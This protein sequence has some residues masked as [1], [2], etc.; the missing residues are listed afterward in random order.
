MKRPSFLENLFSGYFALVMAT[1]IVSIATH[2]LKMELLAYSLFKI[3]Q[4]CYLVLVVLTLL[5]LIF[6]P[7][8]I[9]LDLT[10]HNRGPGFFTFVAGSC[11]LGIQFLFFTS[12]RGIPLGLWLGGFLAWFIVMYVFFTAATVRSPK[13]TLE[14]G[15]NGAWLLAVVATQSLSILGTLL[16]KYVFLSHTT[17]VLFL[18]LCMFLLGCMIYLLIISVIFQRLMFVNVEAKT[19]TPPYWINMGAVAITTLAGATLVAN[20]AAWVFLQQIEPFLK[21]FTLFFWA[22]CSWWI[23]LL[24]ILGVWRHLY[25]K[26]ALT[27]DPQ[28]WGMVFPLGMYVTCTYRLAEIF[29]FDF[30]QVI[31]RYF[32]FIPIVVWAI[33][34]GGMVHQIVKSSRLAFFNRNEN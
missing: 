26:V 9:F 30:L 6:F 15:L 16:T 18:S 10:D 12:S 2:L 20:A 23:P 3:N 4:V 7:R 32:V 13:P 24:F 8:Q 22:T 14:N 27:Y 25:K 17:E 1:G 34:F 29:K 11:V 21:G 5:R 31:P 19:L 33:A 28:Y